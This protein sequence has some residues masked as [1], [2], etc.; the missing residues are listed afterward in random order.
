MNM[1]MA[2]N[3]LKPPFY[4]V[5]CSFIKLLFPKLILQQLFLFPNI[6]PDGISWN[7]VNILTF[8][9]S[10]DIGSDTAN[11]AS[12]LSRTKLAELN[13][14]SQIIPI[15]STSSKQNTLRKP[16]EQHSTEIGIIFIFDV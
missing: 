4:M 2:I 9:I 6:I 12:A 5:G 11:F 3:N 7:F 10:V 8:Q 13:G 16:T 15:A 1:L 14:T